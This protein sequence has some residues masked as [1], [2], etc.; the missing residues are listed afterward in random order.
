MKAATE[1]FYDS[2]IT[3]WKTRAELLQQHLTC[4]KLELSWEEMKRPAH[5]VTLE[6][7]EHNNVNESSLCDAVALFNTSMVK[8]VQ[9]RN[10]SGESKPA[11]REIFPGCNNRQLE[12][13]ETMMNWSRDLRVHCQTMQDFRTK[14]ET[15]NKTLSDRIA[16]RIQHDKNLKITE[17]HFKHV[18]ESMTEN[19][20]DNHSF[21]NCSQIEGNKTAFAI[22]TEIPTTIHCGEAETALLSLTD[23]LMCDM[24]MDELNQTYSYD[25]V[26]CFKEFA[27]E[28]TGSKCAKNTTRTCR[29]KATT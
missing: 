28:N 22:N 29:F 9:V 24:M 8:Y 23:V 20:S 11:A 15:R 13:E 2:N 25:D 6:A 16:N 10:E 14:A 17:C 27:K 7:K 12:W 4:R 3:F 18:N 1:D 26:Q 5:N 21:A 19:M